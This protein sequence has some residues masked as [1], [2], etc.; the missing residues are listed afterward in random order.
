MTR[1]IT[2]AQLDTIEWVDRSGEAD[3]MGIGFVKS[4]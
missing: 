2:P 3:V 1:K 4:V